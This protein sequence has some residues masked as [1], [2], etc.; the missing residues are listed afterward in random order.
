MAVLCSL[1]VVV[2][3]VKDLMW[4]LRLVAIHVFWGFKAEDV[5]SFLFLGIQL[6]AG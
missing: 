5:Q 1:I 4:G 3:A 6:K 2:Q